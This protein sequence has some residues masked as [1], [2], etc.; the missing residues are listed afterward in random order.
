[1]WLKRDD[2]RL[3]R[4][5]L[6]RSHHLE[7]ENRILRNELSRSSTPAYPPAI[8]RPMAAIAGG[9]FRGPSPSMLLQ[10]PCMCD[11]LRTKLARARSELKLRDEADAVRQESVCHRHVGTQSLLPVSVD[12][13]SQAMLCVL[14]DAAMQTD[15]P[16]PI[17][18]MVSQTRRA[19]IMRHVGVGEATATSE[20]VGIQAVA[21]P[22]L[23]SDA[24]SQTRGKS[25][26]GGK[27]AARQPVRRDSSTQTDGSRT[28]VVKAG[29]ASAHVQT[30]APRRATAAVQ[31][32]A[33]RCGVDRGTQAHDE[34]AEARE[35]K[36][37]KR[38]LE[39]ED[40][41]LTLKFRKAELERELHELR[42]AV[43]VWR[44]AAE[45]KA[46]GQMNV[47]ILCPRAECTVNGQFLQMDSWDP[48]KLRAEFEREVLPRFTRIFVEDTVAL[49]SCR[50]GSPSSSKGSRHHGGN[51]LSGPSRQRPEAVERA[52]QEFAEVFRERL[53]AML[54][55]H[56][57][58]DA[59]SSSR[60]TRH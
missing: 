45:S 59:L 55:A 48:M 9:G 28:T 27:I 38:C 22:P 2:N 51:F 5:E 31:V 57:S 49:P 6:A 11:A 40:L 56:D 7:D 4:E 35:W 24:A 37:R 46:L 26:D 16:L 14:A 34:E 1:M 20:N 19:T 43:D 36:S 18:P 23:T 58:S 39:L 30:V 52:M 10:K 50:T 8:R 41:A 17:P 54:S 3:L 47:T 29:V 42:E 15:A 32:T 33:E 13:E 60:K 21:P 12:A 25:K 44:N 53:S